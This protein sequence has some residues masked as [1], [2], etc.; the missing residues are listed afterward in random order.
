MAETFAV[1]MHR[2]AGMTDAGIAP[3]GKQPVDDLSA[4]IPAG[5]AERATYLKGLPKT[6]VGRSAPRATGGFAL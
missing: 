5:D 6:S 2:W 1:S 4:E 3:Q